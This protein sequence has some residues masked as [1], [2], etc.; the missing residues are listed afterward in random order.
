MT[1]SESRLNEAQA[2]ILLQQFDA[3]LNIILTHPDEPVLDLEIHVATDMLSIQQPKIV[4]YYTHVKLLHQ[5]VEHNAETN[6]HSTALEF[7][8]D[9]EGTKA[10]WSYEQLNG[11]ANHVAHYLV[12]RGIEQQ[13]PIA[14]CFE[15]SPMAFICILAVLK[16]GSAFCCL[17]ANAPMD[18]RAFI[19]SNCK[20]SMV[21]CSDIYEEELTS[22]ASVPVIPDSVLAAARD[23]QHNLDRSISEDNLSYI[24]YTSGST[25]TPKGCCISHKSIV[26]AMYSFRDQFCQQYDTESRFLAFAS[27]HFDVSILEQYFSWS[28]GARVCAAPRDVLLS[29]IP[30]AIKYFG[31]THLDLTPQLAMTLLPED[32][33]SLRVFITGGEMLRAETVDHWGGS[34]VL[35]NF[36]GPTEVTI[37]CTALKRVEK[38]A[39]P[40]NIGQPWLNCGIIVQSVLGKAKPALRG[41][42]GDLIV[43]GSQVGA[44]YMDLPDAT[45]KRFA[46]SK[47]L[48]DRTYATGD[49]VRLLAD[50]SLD[51]AG[52]A[53]SQI[54][55][56]GQRIETGEIDSVLK[57]SDAQVFEAVT[58]VLKHPS[59]QKDQLVSFVVWKDSDRSDAMA[60]LEARKTEVQLR[61]CQEA[62]PP[63]MIPSFLVPVNRIALT[64]THKVDTK[65]LRVLYDAIEP[66]LLQKMSTNSRSDQS[67]STPADP[68]TVEKVR[69]VVQRMTGVTDLDDDS[70]IFELGL[71]SV[72]VVGLVRQ[73][74][75][76]G[77]QTCSV[78]VVMGSVSVNDLARKL[79]AKGPAEDDRVNEQAMSDFTKEVTPVVATE[80]NIAEDEIQNVL[81]CPPLIEGM[82]V[83]SLK[84][85][86]RHMNTFKVSGDKLNIEKLEAAFADLIRRTPMLRSRFVMT[87]RG[88]AHVIVKSAASSTKSMDFPLLSSL[89]EL[90][91]HR[92]SCDITLHHAL[93]DGQSLGMLFDD[94]NTLYASRDPKERPTFTPVLSQMLRPS[95]P[96]TLSFWSDSLQGRDIVLVGR[97]SEKIETQTSISVVSTSHLESLC[98][99]QGCVPVVILQIAWAK[100]LRFLFEKDTIFGLLLSGRDHAIDG[101]EDMM[102]PTFNTVPVFCATKGTKDQDTIRE[103]Q[104]RYGTILGHQHTPLRDIKKSLKVN[105][106]TPLMDS[107]LVFQRETAAE[108]THLRVEDVSTG[109]SGY[110]LALD[111]TANNDRSL[112]FE[113]KV[114]DC[115]VSA[116]QL[117]EIFD[118][119]LA[120]LVGLE[121]RPLETAPNISTRIYTTGGKTN[122][123][124]PINLNAQQEAI[125]KQVLE[126]IGATN[127]KL[128]PAE[129]FF[130]LGLD[131]VDI[132]K[133]SARL[134]QSL[135]VNISVAEI[136]ANPY[137]TA[138]SSLK[139]KK[140]T[141]AENSESPLLE[142]QRSLHIA[143]A[144][145]FETILPVS[146]IQNAMLALS[147]VSEN[148][149]Y[150]NHALFKLDMRLTVPDLQTAWTKLIFS[151]ELLRTSFRESGRSNI[152]VNFMQVVHKD[153]EAH[154]PVI[155]TGNLEKAYNEHKSSSLKK[156]KTEDCVPLFACVIKDGTDCYLAISIHHC[157]YDGISLGLILSDLDHII[158]GKPLDSRPAFALLL[159][160]IY[161]QSAVEADLY[162][163]RYLAGCSPR[164]LLE[165]ELT[166]DVKSTKSSKIPIAELAKC[167]KTIGV[168]IQ[169][170][171]Q[172]C[173]AILLA[174]IQGQEDVL[175]GTIH[176]GR[177]F[178]PAAADIAGPCMNTITIRAQ[179]DPTSTYRSLMQ[180]LHQNNIEMADYVYTPLKQV[181]N[182]VGKGPLFET[183]FVYQ[184][185]RGAAAQSRFLTPVEEYSESSVE[186]PLAVEAS[187]GEDAL[188][189]T[190]AMQPEYYESAETIFDKLEDTLQKIVQDSNQLVVV[191]G[192][193]KQVENISSEREELSEDET[194]VRDIL[195]E[196]ASAASEIHW[197]TSIFSLGLDSISVIQL[198][199]RLKQI[200]LKRTVGQILRS[201][202]LRGICRTRHQT[203]QST[204]IQFELS[205]EAWSKA[206]EALSLEIE[207]I[208][209]IAPATASQAYFLT[210]WKALEGT[211]FMSNF[212]FNIVEEPE[213]VRQ[214][215]T[216][217]VETQAIMRTAFAILEGELY[218]V[219]L[220]Q[221]HSSIR[222]FSAT[223]RTPD[224]AISE[225]LQS[226]AFVIPRLD[227]PPAHLTMLRCGDKSL[228]I[229][230]IHHALY[231][232]NSISALLSCLAR[233]TEPSFVSYAHLSKHLHSQ[234]SAHKTTDYWTRYLSGVAPLKLAKNKT[235][236]HLNSLR[237]V[238]YFSI[239]PDRPVA[240]LDKKSKEYSVTAQSILIAAI[241]KAIVKQENPT[242]MGVYISG[243]SLDTPGIDEVFGPV[244]NILPIRVDNVPEKSIRQQAESIHAALIDMNGIAQHQSIHE[245]SKATGLH[246]LVDVSI[247]I[248]PRTNTRSNLDEALDDYGRFS[249]SHIATIRERYQSG[250][251]SSIDDYTGLGLIEPRLDIEVEIVGDQVNFGVFASSG[252]LDESG[253]ELI[254]SSVWREIR[255]S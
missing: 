91:T 208:E 218:Q 63:Y 154:L 69:S 217:L 141:P 230:S 45:K 88:L 174:E 128:N 78:A 227:R 68:E 96:D 249:P 250:T 60:V 160:H 192:L 71:D 210:A 12:N 112:Q 176:T 83:E 103:T 20:A 203:I 39:R 166:K 179:I 18:R 172:A 234:L 235:M 92:D 33:K 186:F 165:G 222:D 223:S 82:I 215:W 207:V 147:A 193:R 121:T 148:G 161:S 129:S 124:E 248:L 199:R 188:Q 64:A 180:D 23:G 167:S 21:L 10:T 106:K 130:T 143:D 173:Y 50:D 118:I 119:Y 94:L 61:A 198:S 108:R 252:V 126:T 162:W 191:D 81:P 54:K 139:M 251:R 40:S 196:F 171:A 58:V 22:T 31:I 233:D 85:S 242:T 241:A 8:D 157:L 231:D 56:R 53:D 77:L 187:L 205:D 75:L 142:F 97:L 213:K 220:K 72:S 19:I 62:L 25:G 101:I 6:P 65:K 32:A 11:A 145:T 17:D 146:P 240:V 214:R 44:G 67:V 51:F 38:D 127:Q 164:L 177:T 134:K 183:L 109:S 80:L 200:G 57:K 70:S 135:K 27:L 155:E 41:A 236:A 181:Q 117:L 219:V 169:S 226:D 104:R 158:N 197:D 202:T 189:W 66:D 224:A 95:S 28:V 133:L 107:V 140:S 110:A 4:N 190:V 254:I 37:G 111:V 149:L 24:L 209:D 138:L 175:F 229:L 228:V 59:Q 14:I 42:I 184:N 1:Y 201:P 204:S 102:Y 144:D 239:K 73:L 163:D 36:Y 156:S 116:S 212:V 246:G 168:T 243:R 211:R 9:L 216:R 244:V 86:A 132:I 13:H 47:V 125:W 15:K 237:Q 170:L 153:I 35:F 49:L 255:H 152:K 151:H 131:S 74:K 93:Y 84:S 76:A 185:A 5:F 43:S 221:G 2:K 247:N 90:K 30:G 136:M 26:Q 137:V 16:T 48:N 3:V 150:L 105:A 123:R 194:K 113:A 7:T 114:E 225:F 29:D 178:D 245:I 34:G 98:R 206:A 182:N 46:F 253:A 100:T 159:E 120:E 232:A 52:R 99:A 89:I 79:S 195:L 122:K 87:T 55:L 115:G 238:D